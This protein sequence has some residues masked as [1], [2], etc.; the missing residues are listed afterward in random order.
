MRYM[1]LIYSDETSSPGP[2]SAEWDQMMVEFGGFRNELERRGL[3]NQSAPLQFTASASTVRVRGRA[4]QVT[5]G[6]FAETK[7]QL[8]G[9]YIIAC[10]DAAEARELAA[11]IP[12]AR[13]GSIEVRPIQ[14]TT[15]SVAGAGQPLWRRVMID[16][17]QITETTAQATAKI[18]LTIPRDEMQHVMG[19]GYTELM[20]VVDEQ[21]IGAGPWLNHH[22]KMA[23]ETFDFEISVPVRAAVKPAGRVQ[24]G[25]LPAARVARTVYYGSYEGLG[26][27]WGEFDAWVAANGHTPA[28][29]LWEVYVAGP[30]TG[31][32]PANYR[33]EL[34]RPLVG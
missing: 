21:G 14:E 12:M 23:P 7:E 27:A 8:G 34:N 16:T 18:H 1:F 2:G 15:N 20:A 22:L 9:F 6:P 24:P 30:E 4:V 10:Q 5:D 11:M 33:T 32:D 29:N 3:E 19:P 28:A 25:E 17:P 26:E 31:P 13:R